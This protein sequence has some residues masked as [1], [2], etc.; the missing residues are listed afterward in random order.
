MEERAREI[1]EALGALA[2]DFGKFQRAYELV[3]THLGNAQ[4]QYE[5]A[6][7]LGVRIVERFGRIR[8]AGGDKVMR[9]EGGGRG[10]EYRVAGDA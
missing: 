7:R 9:E 6:E 2:L 1:L 5:E 3:G 8:E 4:R 10:E